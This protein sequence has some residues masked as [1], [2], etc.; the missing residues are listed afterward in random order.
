MCKLKVTQRKNMKHPFLK[1]A[2][3]ST[4]YVTNDFPSGNSTAHWQPCN[5]QRTNWMLPHSESVT[6]NFNQLGYRGAW[7]RGDVSGS[8]WCLGDS[9]TAGMGLHEADVW[10]SQ[11]QSKFGVKTVNLG[12]AGASNDTIARTLVAALR[13]ARPLAVCVLVAAPNRREIINDRG[14]ST[15]FPQAIEFIDTLDKKLFTQYLDSVDDTSNRVNY[16]KNLLLMRASCQALSIPFIAIDFTKHVWELAQQ[17]PAL[18]GMHL[19]P[20]I[21][22]EIANAFHRRLQ[23]TPYEKTIKNFVIMTPGRTGSTLIVGNLNR[24][25]G[26]DALQMHHNSYVPPDNTYTCILSRRKNIFDAVIS[27]MVVE[28]TQETTVYSGTKNTPLYISDRDFIIFY[29]TYNNF[30][31]GIDLSKYHCVV[32]VYYEDLISDPY[33]LF[34]KFNISEETRYDLCQKSPYNKEQLIVNYK[35]LQEL[36]KKLNGTK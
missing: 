11:L 18:D 15:F 14:Q 9:Q 25:F 21:H 29:D 10:P 34:S 26:C 36:Y 23:L 30:Y 1:I 3:I 13:S 20:G 22:T 27:Q 5:E 24:Y 17:D 16:D 35:E 28:H 6:Y 4:E 32:D 7:T 12:I 33:Y 31:N 2:E 8:V 19:G